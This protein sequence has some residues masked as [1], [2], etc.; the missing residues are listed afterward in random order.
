MSHAIKAIHASA[1][2]PRTTNEF[3]RALTD[4]CFQ[5]GVAIEG[6][7]ILQMDMGWDG[8][9][10]EK[11]EQYALD[12]NAIVRGFWNQDPTVIVR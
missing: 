7:T 2:I 8:P 12:G 3:T 10:A 9:D 6:G 11:W 1:N 4:L 5:Y